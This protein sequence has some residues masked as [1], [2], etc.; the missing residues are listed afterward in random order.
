M[1]AEQPHFDD[2]RTLLSARPVVPLEAIEAKVKHRRRWF[3]GGAFAIAMFLGAASALVS[4]YLKLRQQP[5]AEIQ[6]SV[7]LTVAEPVAEPTSEAPLPAVEPTIENT[8]A[9]PVVKVVRPKHQPPRVR[10]TDQPRMSEDDALRQ[11]RNS[12][13]VD[14]WE[15]RR[16]R[17]V[18]RRERRRAQHSDRDLSNID[19]IFEGRRGRP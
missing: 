7:V 1:T 9:Q 8:E 3:L 4:A 18:E 15:E 16:A 6:S 2:E 10:D 13:L 12:V 11:I 5:D 17:R 14:Q 19:E